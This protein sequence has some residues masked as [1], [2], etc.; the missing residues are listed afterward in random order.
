[1]IPG[2]QLAQALL[3]DASGR[4]ISVHDMLVEAKAG[5]NS[6]PCLHLG[7]VQ[8]GIARMQKPTGACRHC[9][10][11]MPFGMAAKGNQ[12]NLRRKPI[13][14]ANSVEPEPRLT[15]SAIDTPVADRVPHRRPIALAGNKTSAPFSRAALIG[16]QVDPGER[17]VLD[18]A[19]VIEIQ[20]CQDDV[21]D[22]ACSEAQPF[23][24]AQRR[25]GFLEPDI[26]NCGP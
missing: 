22:I 4:S 18:A 16:K 3:I 17:K 20:M 14:L 19:G 15:C 25:P 12:Q 7:V 6:W 24:L 8:V 10:A 11:G 23:D 2:P 1:M 26:Q 21:P 9:N 13:Q 5:R